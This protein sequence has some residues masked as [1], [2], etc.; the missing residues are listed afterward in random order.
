[1]VRFVIYEN[2]NPYLRFLKYTCKIL[3]SD[4]LEGCITLHKFRGIRNYKGFQLVSIIWVYLMMY[5][6][7]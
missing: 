7:S 2:I 6:V 1:M 5:Q 3:H 4:R